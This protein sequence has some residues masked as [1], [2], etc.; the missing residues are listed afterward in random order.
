LSAGG[1]GGI[2]AGCR[3]I[4]LAC[5]GERDPA[6]KLLFTVVEPG[7]WVTS[8]CYVKM[9]SPNPCWWVPWTEVSIVD[10]VTVNVERLES[11]YMVEVTYYDKHGE[12]SRA[13]HY[14]YPIKV[15][16]KVEEAVSP[17][18]EGRPPRNPGVIF[19]GPPG[20][21]K[22]S[23]L[24]I[25]PDYLGLSTIEAGSEHVLSKWVGE[26]ETNMARL[27]D[28][29]EQMQPS[30][31]LIDEGDWIL[32]PVRTADG[33]GEVMQNVLGVVKR[34]LAEHYKRGALVLTIF[35]ANLAESAIDSTFKRE[36]RCGKPIVI[37]LPDYEAVYSYLERVA[38][39]EP[40][41]AERMALDAVNAGL[42]MADVVQMANTF[43]ETG[44]YR[45][46]PM[47]YRGYR[48]HIVGSGVMAEKGVPELLAKI[49]EAFAF[50]AIA[51]YPKARVWISD[52]PAAISLPI[53]SAAIG[54]GARKPVVVLDHEKYVD[55]AVDMIN[56]LGAV[57]VVN[58]TV[59]HT[60]E[61]KMLWQTADFP[62]IFIG[63]EPP[64]VEH[65]PLRLREV[66]SAHR[67]GTAKLLATAYNITLKEAI[68]KDLTSTT[69]EGFFESLEKLVLAGR[70]VK[71][72]LPGI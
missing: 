57:A 15:W 66:L 59:L 37:P 31:L 27:F 18:A 32:S 11:N 58:H 63:M 16:D 46:E 28:T 44:R 6:R 30:A 56:L 48:R 64:A 70:I 53:V 60:S 4:K 22:T 68:L 25:L 69:T 45:V 67:L 49:E 47:K 2:P 35:A 12:P 42:S 39:I 36:G 3:S 72:K 71:P 14:V 1:D 61:V 13:E 52:L 50:T 55:E 24:H 34:R 17:L 29:A 40:G 5:F 62:T 54:L 51:S 43:K 65:H 9:A 20:T 21:G 33:M 8:Y 26:S 7:M 10:H 38:G 41:T 23:L 19:I